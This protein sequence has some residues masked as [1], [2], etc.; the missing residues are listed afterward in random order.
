MRK[1]IV[2]LDG[3]DNQ[4]SAKNTNVVRLFQCLD[5]DPRIQIVRYDPG[6]GTIWEPG[7]LS[8]TWQKTQ[9]LIG[10]AF[11]LGVTRIVAGAYLFLMQ[12]Y[13]T[14]DAIYIFGFS[15]GA[16]EA[17][18]LAALI[19]RCGLLQGQ[20]ASLQPYA[21]RLF[22]VPGNFPVVDSFKATFSHCVEITFLGLWDTVT[23]YGNVWTPI[24]WPNVT[25]NPSVR[26]VA[27]ASAIDERRAFFPRIDGRR[28][29]GRRWTSSGFRVFTA[30]SVAATTWRPAGCGPSPWSGCWGTPST[31][32]CVLSTPTSRRCCRKG[33]HRLPTLRPV[34]TTA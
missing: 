34:S 6:V 14:G 16:L 31:P 4:F 33:R 29:P 24:N 7:T 28:C 32:I 23:S 17:R 8:K 27:H 3:T 30:M 20:L 18:A 13:Q 9:M 12:T 21:M 1:L 15:R 22:E 10:L 26:Q 5:R 2:C 25:R 11:G 19:H